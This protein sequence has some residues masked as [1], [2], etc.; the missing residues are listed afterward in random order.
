[1]T[2]RQT[3][4]RFWGRTTMDD[5][6][7]GHSGDSRG[8]GVLTRALGRSIKVLRADRGL[9][10]RQLADMAGISYSYLTEIENGNKPASNTVLGPIADALGVRLHEL[11]ADA[12]NRAVTMDL[13]V[14]DR[15][16][17]CP[18][19][20]RHWRTGCPRPGA[21]SSTSD[22][23]TPSSRRSRAVE[24][25]PTPLF[26]CG[27]PRWRASSP[28]PAIATTPTPHPNEARSWSWS[29]STADSNPTTGNG[30]ST[31]R[32]ASSTE[33]SIDERLTWTRVGENAVPPL[34]APAPEIVG[35]V[36]SGSRADQPELGRVEVAQPYAVEPVG[37]LEHPEHAL[38]GSRV[39]DGLR[40]ARRRRDPTSSGAP[41]RR[42]PG[43]GP[44]P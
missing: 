5:R 38:G 11:I 8:G 31:S 2:P 14:P 30:C 12:E 41:W 19:R 1:M 6:P 37:I 22:P 23:A 34:V 28:P 18:P 3:A 26:E 21:G 24:N 44:P 4:G 9:G 15:T 13:T 27:E 7:S 33:A 16:D 42:R 35:Q 39:A 17:P 36:D 10:R 32:D 20:R 40:R 29:T 43:R 25:W